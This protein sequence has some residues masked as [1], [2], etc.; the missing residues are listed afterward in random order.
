ML[1]IDEDALICDLAETYHI[2]NYKALPAETVA[3]FA[4]GLRENSRIKQKINKQ[5]API[6]T[7]LLAAAVDRL[8]LMLWA[9]TEDGIKGRN[10]PK[11][12]AAMLSE[13]ETEETGF[14]SLEEFERRLKELQKGG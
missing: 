4:S 10:R 11:A 6:E 1:R 5:K 2:M 12:I 9:E 14:E 13:E 7:I 3:L 8:T